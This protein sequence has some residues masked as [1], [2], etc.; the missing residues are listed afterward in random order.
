MVV[1]R[2]WRLH[3]GP[4]KSCKLSSRRFSCDVSFLISLCRRLV[5][6]ESPAR[7]S[8]QALCCIRAW[9]PSKVSSHAA[10]SYEAFPSL[11]HIDATFLL[12]FRLYGVGN[13]QEGRF[14]GSKPCGSVRQHW[15][16]HEWCVQPLLHWNWQSSSSSQNQLHLVLLSVAHWPCYERRWIIKAPRYYPGRLF[17]PHVLFP[18]P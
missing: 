7:S 3:R 10:S 17:A 11:G 13:T 9:Q 16:E 12:Q 2:D 8:R 4:V 18:A 1:S 6:G 14:A 5:W 15:L